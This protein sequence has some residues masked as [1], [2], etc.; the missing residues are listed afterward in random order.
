MLS[1]QNLSIVHEKDLRL[2]MENIS[3]TLSGKDRLAVI[4]EEGN[5]K[6]TLLKAVYDPSLISDYATVTGVISAPGEKLG[7]LPQEIPPENLTL[8]VYEYCALHDAFLCCDPKQLSSLCARVHISTGTVYSDQKVSTLSGGEKVKLQLL[9]LLLEEPTLLLLDEPSNDLDLKTLRFLEHFLLTCDLPVLFISHDETLLSRTATCILHLEQAYHKT[10]PWWT[11]SRTSYQTYMENREKALQYQE[12]QAQNERRQERIRQEKFDRIQQAV[13]HA[14]SAI[15][16]QDPHGGRLLKKKMKAVKSLEKRFEREK[17]DQTQRPNIEYAIDAAFEGD[18]TVPM[19]KRVLDWNLAVLT[20]DDR[21]LARDIHLFMT[22]PEK[23]ILIGDN[24]CG[25]TTL[26]KQIA[27]HLLSRKDLRAVYM[28]QH[29]GDLLSESQTPV[30]FLHTR[31]DKEQLTKAR[32]YLGALKITR[33]EMEH[34]IRDL[35]GGQKAKLLLL[36]MILKEANVLILDE[37]TRNLSPLSAPVFREMITSFEG[38]VLTITHDRVLMDM[39][40]GRIL[41]LTQNGLVPVNQEDIL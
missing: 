29:Y 4:G 17:E 9:L 25:K 21:V 33:E 34:P 16:R 3:F 31:G 20:A 37:P 5:G 10:T 26:M 19:G 40:P 23:V 12:Q 18:N 6:S 28:P 35:S 39:W 41:R 27:S 7:Y 2:L 13:E 14:Q 36:S 15:S 32:T 30:E 11:F 8:S 1:V 24:G 22:G 38:A